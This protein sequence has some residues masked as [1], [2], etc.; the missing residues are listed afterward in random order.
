[1]ATGNSKTKWNENILILNKDIPETQKNYTISYEGKIS[2]TEILE[3]KYIGEYKKIS[4]NHSNNELY[5]GDNID[6][7]RYLINEKNMSEKF[8]LIYIDPPYSTKSVFHSRNNKS[9]YQDLLSGASYIE[10]LRQRLILM[11]KLLKE[12]GSIYIHLDNNMIFQIKLI[13]DEIFGEKNFKGLITR[14][15]CSNKNTTKKTYGNISD[16][17]LFYTKSDKYIWNRPMNPWDETKMKKEYNYIEE[18]TGRRYK[19]VPIHAPGT[20]NGKTGEEWKGMLPPPGKHWQYIPEKLD[21]M[22]K[23]GEIHWSVNGNPRRKVYFDNSKGIPV[24]DIWLE[25]QDS[26]N[27]NI[28]ITGYPTE[29]NN[30]ILERI[31]NASSNEGDLILDCFSGSGTTLEE[32]SKLKRNWIGI[33]NSSEAINHTLKRFFNGTQNMGDYVTKNTVIQ[34]IE[35]KKINFNLIS[36]I[37]AFEIIKNYFKK[38][39]ISKNNHN[40][41]NKKI[42]EAIEINEIKE[43]QLSFIC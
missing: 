39:S 16:Y 1:M 17:I 43:E 19:K 23:N 15:K 41:E 12:T 32:A 38:W 35:K 20:R 14:K 40:K 10:F 34:K 21:E 13:M 30:L 29:K 11:K 7:M 22:D 27:Q 18:N 6:V 4:K 9:S 31:I 25:M 28:K 3:K 37:E 36:D 24:Q 8:T 42:L 26:L 33:D 5:Y 2:E